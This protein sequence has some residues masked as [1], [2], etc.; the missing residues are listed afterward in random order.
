MTST[1]QYLYIYKTCCHSTGLTVSRLS[2][3]VMVASPVED[4]F[5][6]IDGLPA[7]SKLEAEKLTG[8]DF[9]YLILHSRT[10]AWN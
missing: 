6:M 4:F 9:S 1:E 7:A 5:L 3:D 10:C 2:A 8:T